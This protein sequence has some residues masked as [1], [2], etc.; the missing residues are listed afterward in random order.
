M[1]LIISCYFTTNR[2][3]Q[4]IVVENFQ[5]Y[6]KSETKKENHT[7]WVCNKAKCSASITTNS[8]GEIIKVNNSLIPK[9]VNLA[10]Y[11]GHGASTD[12]EIKLAKFE[13]KSVDSDWIG[14]KNV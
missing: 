6:F 9:N 3:N 12:D 13:G 8:N 4:A 5:Y 1:N 7:R 14:F 10:S 11:H 2:N